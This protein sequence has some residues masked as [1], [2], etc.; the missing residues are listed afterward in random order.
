MFKV[1][2]TLLNGRFM[3]WHGEADHFAHAVEQALKQA[4]DVGAEVVEINHHQE[5]GPVKMWSDLTGKPYI[6]SWHTR[7][8]NTW[9]RVTGWKPTERES[10]KN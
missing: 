9:L 4:A 3:V 6:P 8:Q 1:T 7:V 5:P 10:C 2:M